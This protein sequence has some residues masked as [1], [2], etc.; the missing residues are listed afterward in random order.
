[1]YIDSPNDCRS[2]S[3]DEEDEPEIGPKA[4][5]GSSRSGTWAP[6]FTQ[7]NPE[8]VVLSRA[9]VLA[10]RSHDFLAEA[11]S[12]NNAVDWS[13][14]FH[15]TPSSFMSY[16]TLLQVDSDFIVDKECSSTESQI[17]VYASKDG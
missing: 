13:V 2:R 5:I 10:K 16:S 8:F 15:E 7:H 1:M 4:D 9:A 14:V 11:L 3:D 12:S 17:G 6:T